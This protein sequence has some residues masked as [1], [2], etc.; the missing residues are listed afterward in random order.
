MD[1]NDCGQ[2]SPDTGFVDTFAEAARE[3]ILT[4][5]DAVVDLDSMLGRRRLM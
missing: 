4:I 1:E 5:M 2:F 3:R